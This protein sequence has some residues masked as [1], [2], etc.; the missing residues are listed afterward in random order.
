MIK[1]VVFDC[2]YGGELFADQLKQEYPFIE[3]I[4]VI[5][6]RN[7][8]EIMSSPRMARKCAAKALEPYIGKVDLIILANHLLSITSLKYFR[9]KYNNQKFIGFNL[10][11]PDTF[12][13]REI[14]ILTTKAITRTIN[15]HNFIMRIKRKTR[16]LI[17]DHWVDK[18]DEGAFHAAELR[19]EFNRYNVSSSG[20]TT[21][22]ILANSVF[23]DLKPILK[24]CYSRNLKIHDS[25]SDAIR[26]TCK[27]LGIR[28]GAR[29]K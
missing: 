15:Y 7:S 22:L 10:K 19:A 27:V 6:W 21:E 1:I 8:N 18:I 12:A 17:L 3:I 9:Q 26:E 20:K 23:N 29:R 25:F 2:T 13:D 4:R 5:D 16:T 11:K 14:I 28:G 24:E